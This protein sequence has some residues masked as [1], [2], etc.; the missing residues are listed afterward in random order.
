M[1]AAAATPAHADPDKIVGER[2]GDSPALGEQLIRIL[3]VANW[4]VHRRPAFAGGVLLIA[5][6][7]DGWDVRAAGATVAGAASRLFEQCVAIRPGGDEPVV[8]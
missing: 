4:A 5:T 8:F 7:P 6:H 1:P 2:L 3:E